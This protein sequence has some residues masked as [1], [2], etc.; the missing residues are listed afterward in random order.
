[1]GEDRIRGAVGL[2]ESRGLRVSLREDITASHRYLAGDDRRRLEELVC[3]LGDPQIRAVF[4]ARGGY[5]SQRLLASL[6]PEGLGEP[7]AVIGFSDNTAL[8]EFL[9][10][11]GWAVLHGP[12]PRADHP[13]ELD[14]VLGCLGFYGQPARPASLGLRSW[15]GGIAG[16]VLAEVGGG[17]LSLLASSAGT[18]YAFRAAGRIVYLEDVNEPVYRLDR[19]LYQLRA[20]GGL[21][22]ASAVV[23]GVPETF[24]SPGDAFGHLEDLLSEFAASMPFPVLSGVSSGHGTLNL[25]LPF[26]PRALLDPERGTLAFVEDLVS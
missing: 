19:M 9:R 14:A 15:G 10:R 13:D 25:P 20:S 26:G 23:F 18:P 6:R 22:E 24:L 11:A 16:P 12:H 7:R 8:L 4:L 5:G 21:A 17:C 3:A 1:M 2:L